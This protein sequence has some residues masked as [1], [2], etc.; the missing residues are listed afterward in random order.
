[1]DG[2]DLLAKY[3][4]A[5]SSAGLCQAHLVDDRSGIEVGAVS[6]GNCGYVTKKINPKRDNTI[7]N[8]RRRM[9]FAAKT[10]LL[11]HVLLW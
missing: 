7:N 4:S 10:L 1:M 5:V 11:R 6:R 8:S 2:L 3:L 9:G